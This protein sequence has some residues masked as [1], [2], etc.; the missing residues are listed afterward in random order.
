MS[1][2]PVLARVRLKRDVPAH[3]FAAVLAPDDRERAASVSHQLLWSLFGSEKG[4]RDF[5]WRQ[6]QRDEWLVLGARAPTDH[7]GLFDIECKEFAPS[8]T[9]GDKLAFTL[10]VNPTVTRVG[11]GGRSQRHDIVMDALSTLP[12]RERNAARP[13]ALHTAANEWLTRQGEG[14]GFAISTLR[15]DGYERM[16][17]PRQ[18]NKPPVVFGALDLSGVLEVTDPV[19]FLAKLSQGFGRARAFGCGLMLVKRAH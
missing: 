11:A 16:Q 14:H 19:L 10:R 15:V 13:E 6:T 12:P 2:E 9:V 18:R 8:L 7:H 1:T 5:L 3:S 4:L 17:M